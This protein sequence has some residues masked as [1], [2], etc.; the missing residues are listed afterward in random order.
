MSS[1]RK[2]LSQATTAVAP[3]IRAGG[4]A[5]PG[6]PTPCQEWVLA[7]LTQH[8]LGTTA[9]LARLGRRE[10]LDATD[11]WGR[12]VSDL[13]WSEQLSGQLED[14]AAAWSGVGAWQ[15]E[16]DMGGQQMPASMI[17]DMV[18]AEVVLHGWDLARATGQQLDV[19][20]AVAHELRRGIE[21]TADLGRQMGAYGEAVEVDENASDLDH[22]LGAAGRD[23]AWSVH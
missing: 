10:P 21:Q 1:M 19:P 20:D 13:P 18:L 7:D 5:D 9:G 4:G 16:V 6:A 23:P 14:L 8:A 11:P 3:I 17:G 12:P 2:I 22:A 15:G